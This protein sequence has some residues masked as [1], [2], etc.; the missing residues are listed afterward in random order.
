MLYNIHAIHLQWRLFK[1]PTIDTR[2]EKAGVQKV[3]REEWRHRC[4]DQR[5]QIS[6]S[7]KTFFLSRPQ[8]AS[9]FH[10]HS[11]GWLI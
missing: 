5:Y 11:A 1:L 6:K 3:S 2:I 8:H 4:P 7:Y 9:S 10:C